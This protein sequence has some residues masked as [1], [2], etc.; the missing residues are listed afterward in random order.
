LAEHVKEDVVVASTMDLMGWLRKHLEAADTDLL[1]EMVLGF[2]QALMSAEADALCG[3]SLGER[4]ADRVNQRNGYRERRL[5]TRV[6]TLELAIPKLRAGSY[7]PEWLLEPRRRAE[8]A[9]VAVVAE[10]YVRGISTR[11]VE[12]LVQTLGIQSL[13]KSQ[14][15]ELAKS[16]DGEVTAFRGRPLDAGP[17]PYVWVDALAVRCREQGRIVNVACVLATGVGA[18]GHREILGVD[19]LTSEDGAGWTSFLRGLVARGLS[20]VELVVSDAHQGLKQAIAAVLPGAGWQRCRTHFM[21]NL[22]CR[23]PKSAQG[24]VATLVRSIF[25]QPDAGSTLAQHARIVEQLEDRFPA[26]A[27]LLA[28]AAEEL[29]AFTA[30][31]KEHWRQI[32]S[33][34]PQER[35]N[36]ELRRRTDVVGI[37][38]NRAAVLR[39]VGAVLAEQHDEWAVAR[40]YM[41]AESLAKTHIRV[42]DGES[43]QEEVKELAA[44]G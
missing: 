35:L 4:S 18:D 31:P 9:L 15:S 10:C 14:V 2:V 36:K 3:A 30:F 34:N 41:S 22:L 42:I 13:S 1:R 26:A 8:R 43:E 39:L 44:A 12:G 7:Y 16:L 37:F 25:A 32:W 11:R 20:G 5:D 27:E 29:L 38:P 17:Y 21:R 19:V 28:D 23:V 33:N 40:R 24:L 6:G